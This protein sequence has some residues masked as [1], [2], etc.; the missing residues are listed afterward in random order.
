MLATTTGKTQNKLDYNCFII[1]FLLI[2]SNTLNI[3]Y[4]FHIT[5][6][7]HIIYQVYNITIKQNYRKTKLTPA[8]ENKPEFIEGCVANVVDGHI[9]V[10]CFCYQRWASHIN[11]V[12]QTRLNNDSQCLKSTQL[13]YEQLSYEF[14]FFSRFVQPFLRFRA[15]RLCLW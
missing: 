15:A 2:Y 9:Q 1:V 13:S 5:I 4:Y 12:N 10:E 6:H 3:I 7:T 14:L 11:Q 8:A